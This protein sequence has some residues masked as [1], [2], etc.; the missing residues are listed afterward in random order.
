MSENFKLQ[1][2]LVNMKQIFKQC[3]KYFAGTFY[4]V[5]QNSLH[6][7]SIQITNKNNYYLYGPYV[8]KYLK[9]ARINNAKRRIFF[10]K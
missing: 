9:D 8:T 2:V 1:L 10:K 6:N 7:V 4:F 5:I 3:R